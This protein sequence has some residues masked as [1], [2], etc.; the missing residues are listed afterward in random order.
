MYNEIQSILSTKDN[1]GN[2]PSPVFDETA[3]VKYV[4]WDT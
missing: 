1:S 4:V 3:G 2:T